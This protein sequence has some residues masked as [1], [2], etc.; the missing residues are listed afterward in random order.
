VKVASD[1]SSNLVE[2][3]NASPALVLLALDWSYADSEILLTLHQIKSTWP[4]A[5]TAVLVED[6]KQYQVVQT[7]G[8]DVILFEGIIAAQLLKQIDELLSRAD[9]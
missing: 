7:A 8:A 5:R 6:E 1:H 3:E 4:G 9:L 2:K